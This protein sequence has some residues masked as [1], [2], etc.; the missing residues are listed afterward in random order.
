[1]SASFSVVDIGGSEDLVAVVGGREE[2]S[3]VEA[4]SMEA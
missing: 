2:T 1:M 3:G 4:S